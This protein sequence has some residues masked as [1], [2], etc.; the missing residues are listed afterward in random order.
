MS[1]KKYIFFNIGDLVITKKSFE[2]FQRQNS[3][4]ASTTTTMEKGQKVIYLGAK[5]CPFSKKQWVSVDTPYGAS[6]TGR[7]PVTIKLMHQGNVWYFAIQ[8]DIIYSYLKLIQK[9]HK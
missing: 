1:R 5:L 9:V 7:I 3:G 6:Y 4:I 8:K 2:I